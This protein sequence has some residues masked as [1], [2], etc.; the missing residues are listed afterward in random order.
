MTDKLTEQWLA[1][2]LHGYIEDILPEIRK[3]LREEWEA[4]RGF[5]RCH[6][7][8]NGEWVPIPAGEPCKEG[9]T[10]CSGEYCESHGYHPCDCNVIERHQIVYK[11]PQPAPPATPEPAF[12]VEAC[13]FFLPRLDHYGLTQ[14]L[15][16]AITE[17]ERLR[18]ER[19]KLY[20]ECIIIYAENHKLSQCL[21]RLGAENERRAEGK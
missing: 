14:W 17:I 18:A 3:R 10:R 20:A 11:T 13:K 9:C 15:Q 4:E 7:D 12:D 16:D 21:E 6:E 2:K 1:D 8:V 19:D 5:Y